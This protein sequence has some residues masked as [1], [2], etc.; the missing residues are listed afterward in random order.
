M[1]CDEQQPPA[2]ILRHA[3]I[4]VLGAACSTNNEAYFDCYP[5]IENT[6]ELDAVS[7]LGFSGRQIADLASGSYTVS[8]E[9]RFEASQTRTFNV[10]FVP[11]GTAEVVQRSDNP[12]CVGPLGPFLHV[13]GTATGG[14]DGWI[15]GS[16]EG[17]LSASGPTSDTMTVAISMRRAEAS[18]E[19][20]E[21]MEPE[22]EGWCTYPEDLNVTLVQ[23]GDVDG[24]LT[25]NAWSTGPSGW[26]NADCGGAGLYV[27]H[28]WGAQ[29]PASI[30]SSTGE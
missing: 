28:Q 15:E 25:W 9:S 20:V 27:T 2:S 16:G 21:L 10:S 5:A 23:S 22:F 29:L 30:A 24:G 19:F 18:Q 1:R 7:S 3:I 8:V 4:A 14:F 6:V 11:D 12:N 13:P 17:V 26:V